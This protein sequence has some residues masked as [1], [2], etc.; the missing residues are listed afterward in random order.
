LFGA[1]L[2]FVKAERKA[3]LPADRPMDAQATIYACQPRVDDDG[4]SAVK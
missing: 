1:R 3:F 4:H 2:F